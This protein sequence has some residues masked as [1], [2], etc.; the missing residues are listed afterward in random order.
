[1][2]GFLEERKF[3]KKAHITQKAIKELNHRYKQRIEKN[4]VLH[5][6]MESENKIKEKK[7]EKIQEVC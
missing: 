5:K 7:D 3:K 2:D 4:Y 1:M 6:M